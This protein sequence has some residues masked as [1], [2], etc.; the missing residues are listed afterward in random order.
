[1]HTDDLIHIY[2]FPSLS[3]RNSEVSKQSESVEQK[4][5]ESKLEAS[6][7]C[8][9]IPTIIDHSNNQSEAGYIIPT[10]K[11]IRFTKDDNDEIDALPMRVAP[12]VSY[13][14]E[15][16]NTPTV[17]IRPSKKRTRRGKRAGKKA[18]VEALRF[19]DFVSNEAPTIMSS[20]A[21]VSS[22]MSTQCNEMST[23]CNEMSTQCNEMSTQCNEMSTQCNEMNHNWNETSLLQNE[24]SA[25]SNG[26][27]SSTPQLIPPPTDLSNS[28]VEMTPALNDPSP[29]N[30]IRVDSTTPPIDSTKQEDNREADNLEKT[31]GSTDPTVP[32][33]PETKSTDYVPCIQ[34]IIRYHTPFLDP[35]SRCPIAKE[36]E[37]RVMK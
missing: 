9:P 1:M 13:H 15:N 14:G 29:A 6:E 3:E 34:D 36:V 20:T 28:S 7:F 18:Q 26:A 12:V 33:A 31:G 32:T 23:Q 30:N 11:I 16:T 8:T 21:A 35:E 10:N 17:N 4:S 24:Q 27:I 22:E 19:L 37:G 5:C 2:Y 25:L